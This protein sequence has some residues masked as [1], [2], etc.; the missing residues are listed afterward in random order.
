[1]AIERSRTRVVP[2]RAEG[3]EL[4][5][6]CV[7]KAYRRYARGYDFWFGWLLEPG[8]RTVIE[9]M[10]LQPGQRVL[11]IGV[12]TGLS[13]PLYP[14]TIHVTGV[15]VSPE[16]LAR[17]EAR[18]LHCG[19]GHIELHEMDAEH[20]AFP[21][22][23]FDKVVAMYVVSVVPD[24]AQ[25]LREMQRVCAPGGELYIVNHFRS[26]GLLSGAVERALVPLSRLLGFRPDF[27]L[28]QLLAGSRLQVEDRQP[29]N[30]FGYW[31]CL[32]MR[33]PG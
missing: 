21:G 9:H 14:H 18:R 23:G 17:A 8:R 26:N 30:L 13:L 20:M 27:T 2:P 29:V 16:M 28:E 3:R 4:D 11:E 31:T 7:R 22:G 25:L 10:A 32:Q 6:E 33:T 15:D 24:P 12:G 1:M 19:L 5:M